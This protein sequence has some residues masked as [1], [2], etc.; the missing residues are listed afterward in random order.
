MNILYIAAESSIS[1]ANKSMC[2]LAKKIEK[3]GNNVYVILPAPGP[4]ENELK[5]RNI[6]YKIIYSKDWT[7]TLTNNP[8]MNRL[9]AIKRK[10]YNIKA[11]I[12]I[13][14][15]IKNKD[16]NIVHNNSIS[17]YVGAIAGYK[18]K[19]RVVWHLREFLEEDHGIKIC[20]GFNHKKIINKADCIINISNA[21]YYKYKNIYDVKKMVM[22]YNGIEIK[23]FLNKKEILNKEKVNIAVV[24]RITEGKGQNALVNAINMMNENKRRE[25]NVSL[26]GEN[27]NKYAISLIKKVKKLKLEDIVKFDGVIYEISKCYSNMDIVIVT[28][29]NEAFGRVSVEAMLEGCLV[30]AS[31]TGANSEIISHMKTGLLYENNNDKDLKDKIE[32]AINNKKKSQ[33]IAKN[34]QEY[35]LNNFSSDKNASEILKIYKKIL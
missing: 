25:L 22:I 1:G 12:E 11:I 21:V 31:N 33:I 30:I 27:K 6:Q 16:I 4:I 34:G 5:L 3:E 2:I 13:R 9:R 15:Y 7:V 23:E 26:V 14:K 32:F 19:C 18:E 8:L 10:I 35:A 29:R 17:S 24:G 28:S 20:E